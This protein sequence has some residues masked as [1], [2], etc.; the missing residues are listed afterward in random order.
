MDLGIRGRKAL[1][2]GSSRGMGRACALALAREGVEVTLVARTE[3]T[4]EQAAE[5]IR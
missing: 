5:A 4:L 1:L 3:A 2:F